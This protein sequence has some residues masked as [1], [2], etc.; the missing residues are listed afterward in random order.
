MTKP[1]EPI[2][3]ITTDAMTVEDAAHRVAVTIAA[4]VDSHD[5]VLVGPISAIRDKGRVL[6]VHMAFADRV[7]ALI[8]TNILP[9]AIAIATPKARAL[10]RDAILAVL[11]R[12]FRRVRACASP[13]ALLDAAP[14]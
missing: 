7:G 1:P 4:A 14:P 10:L 11:A 13:R 8:V 6:G 9:N 2:A 3:T 5:V 12:H